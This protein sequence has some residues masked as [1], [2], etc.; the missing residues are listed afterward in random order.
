M[1]CPDF[2]A[3]V[4]FSE[5]R[6]HFSADFRCQGFVAYTRRCVHCASG[7]SFNALFLLTVG[8]ICGTLINTI[9]RNNIITATLLSTVATVIYN[10]GYWLFNV[11][12]AHLDSAFYL[13]WRYYLPSIFF[14][15]LLTPVFFLIIR[16]FEKKFSD[17]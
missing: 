15:S 4:R 8:F 16:S 5:Y 6:R 17:E 1:P 3:A 12:F 9:M 10:V 11:V 7:A 14:T 2:T 13:L